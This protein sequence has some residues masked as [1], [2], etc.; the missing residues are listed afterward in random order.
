MRGRLH[1][2]L[3]IGLDD[4]SVRQGGVDINRHI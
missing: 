4:S 3:V 2:I 1:I